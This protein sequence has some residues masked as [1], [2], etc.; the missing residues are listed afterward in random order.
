MNSKRR[1][2]D[3]LGIDFAV[4]VRC[5]RDN[6]VLEKIDLDNIAENIRICSETA[7]NN[8]ERTL[9][10]RA[11]KCWDACNQLYLLT[12]GG[13]LSLPEK[14]TPGQFSE[15]DKEFLKKLRIKRD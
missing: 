1:A 9:I 6:K 12:R 2:F 14:P 8:D 4:M 7:T 13:E 3:Q 10:Q 11:D 15:S 5:L